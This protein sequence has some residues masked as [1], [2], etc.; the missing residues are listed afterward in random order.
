MVSIYR[1]SLLSICRV[2]LAAVGL[3]YADAEALGQGRGDR[4]PDAPR[5]SKE[6]PARPQRGD[7]I[8][9]R[10]ERP[11]TRVVVR[12]VIKEVRVGP[13]AGAL[14][15][16]LTAGA[17]VAVAPLA[18]DKPGRPLE[19]DLGQNNVLKLRSL[20]PGKYQVRVTHP[21]YQPYTETAVVVKGEVVPLLPP[22]VSKYGSVV[23]GGAARGAKVSLD[24]KTLSTADYNTDG[25]GRIVIP[26]VLVGG[27]MLK[28]SQAGYDDW[29]DQI[30]VKPGD[31]TP[32]AV[33]ASAAT[34][35]LSVRAR[36]GAKVYLDDVERGEVPPSGLIAVPGLKPAPHRLHVQL[37]GFE[38]ADRNLPLTLSERA[39]V[40]SVELAPI[41]ES[42]EAT[43]NDTNPRLN[44]TPD[45]AGWGFEKRGIVVRGEDAVLFKS[46]N[47]RRQFNHYR[48]FTMRLGLSFANGKGAAWIVRARD[49]KNYYLFELTTSKGASGRK[50]FNFYICR[51]GVL[52]LVDGIK[53]VDDID[54]PN[55]Y[56]HV[57]AI[58]RGN[59][60]RYEIEVSTDAKPQRRPLAIFTDKDNTFPIGGVGLLGRGGMETVL[61]QL[62]VFP[63]V[64]K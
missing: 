40:V 25:Q 32:V 3:G 30:E 36:P 49:A 13:S 8:M 43:I 27:H 41:A 7:A 19:Y 18:G 37:D 61:H 4:V 39:P 1:P 11:A 45:P 42:G 2:I 10:E 26:R 28:V 46:A 5:P 50:T 14:V 55:A 23:V 53:V 62:H 20:S 60:F 6:Q 48:D 47:E 57:I 22:L 58:A 59:Q 64:K 54:N 38:P 24:G 33:L 16:W 35:T 12:E 51:D 17:K 34:I 52:K 56:L 44:W 21:D 9:Q 63:E 15:M 31:P 29:S